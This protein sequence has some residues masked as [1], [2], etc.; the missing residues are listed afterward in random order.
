M[1]EQ[2]MLWKI[3]LMGGMRP[4]G[5]QEALRTAT[6]RNLQ[7][8]VSGGSRTLKYFISGAYQKDQGM[9]YHSEYDRYSFRTKLDAQLSK[10]VKFTFNLNPSYIKRERPSVNLY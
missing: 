4:T 1:K 6:V 2:P 3:Q 10:R 5:R 8:N 9:M 7:M